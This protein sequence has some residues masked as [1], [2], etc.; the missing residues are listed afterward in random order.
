MIPIEE[1]KGIKPTWCPGCGNFMILDGIKKA[2]SV[3]SIAPHEVTI[4]SGIGQAAK[5]PLYMGCNV[6]NGLHG[7]ALPLATGARYANHGM[8]TIMIG[9]DGD[10][11]AEGGNHFLHAIR[12]NP[13]LAY[14]VHNNQVYGLTRGQAS[15]TSDPGSVTSTTPGGVVHERFNPAA[16]AISLNASFVART[17]TGATDHM[18][19]MMQLAI[20]HRGF[21]FLEILQH[22]VSYNRVNTIRWYRDHAYDIA[23]DE[24]YDPA[25]RTA[26]FARSLEWGEKFPVGVLYRCDR[27]TMTDSVPVLRE[28]PLVGQPVGPRNI[29][30]LLDTFR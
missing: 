20:E 2:L 11:F 14:F 27:P 29:E 6:L 9:G 12:R 19:E 15:P 10:G 18:V 13:D 25:D 28:G 23:E 3:M 26:A 30:T 5:L 8:K 16:V 24:D 21:A 17:H 22:C 4:F 1:Y 7:R